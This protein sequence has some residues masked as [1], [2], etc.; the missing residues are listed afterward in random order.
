LVRAGGGALEPLQVVQKIDGGK[1]VCNLG[2]AIFCP[3]M[4]FKTDKIC[5]CIL[6]LTNLHTVPNPKRVPKTE[7]GT[8]N[9]LPPEMTRSKSSSTI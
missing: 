9:F 2:Y 4:H 6:F 5:I 3:A 1:G 7:L 8:H